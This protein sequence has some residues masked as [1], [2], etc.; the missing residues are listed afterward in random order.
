MNRYRIS[1]LLQK[2]NRHR[3]STLDFTTVSSAVVESDPVTVHLA[4][5]GKSRQPAHGAARRLADASDERRAMFLDECLERHRR[6]TADLFDEIV[7][8]GENPVLVIDRDLVK[9]LEEEV[10]PG[11]FLGRPLGLRRECPRG[12]TLG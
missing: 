9:V 6:T 3:I 8:A 7:R 11:S 10:I 5:F 12:L 1:T 4:E 2:M